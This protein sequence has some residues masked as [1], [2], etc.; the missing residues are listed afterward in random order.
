M[1]HKYYK[2][3]PAVSP[4]KGMAGRWNLPSGRDK[5]YEIPTVWKSP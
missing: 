1:Y 4:A 2:Y 3:Q 5:F